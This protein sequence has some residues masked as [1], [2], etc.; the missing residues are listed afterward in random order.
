M[1]REFPYDIRG[2][3]TMLACTTLTDEYE[4]E[5][6]SRAQLSINID[7]LLFST[8]HLLAI[9]PVFTYTE[10]ND[11]L[12]LCVIQDIFEYAFLD[13]AF[14]SEH[15]KCPR[16]IWELNK[17]PDPYPFHSKCQRDPRF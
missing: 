15:I 17:V 1:Y 13:N 9:R 8:Y 12:D 5:L 4:L 7:D 11:N 6:R 14:A 2:R 10:R 3:M 16:Y